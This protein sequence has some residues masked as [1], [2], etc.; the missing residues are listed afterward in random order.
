MLRF[1]QRT[2]RHPLG[3]RDRASRRTP[4]GCRAAPGTYRAAGREAG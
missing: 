1:G 3:T 2:R 4:E